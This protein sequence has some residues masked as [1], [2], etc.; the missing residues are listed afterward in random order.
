VATNDLSAIRERIEGKRVVSVESDG[1]KLV[2]DDGTVLHLYISD[3]DCCAHADGRWV[4]RPDSLQAII[5]DVKVTPDEERSGDNG[6]G[7]TNYATVA[8]LHNQ[9]PI[10]LADCYA[11]DGNGGFYF[12]VLSLNVRVPGCDPAEVEVVSA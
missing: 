7:T 4:I 8:I 11:D 1:E 5:T 12:S 6:D 3:S 10:A 2:L 9:N